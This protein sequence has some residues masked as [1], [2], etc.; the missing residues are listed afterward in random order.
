MK[1]PPAKHHR[2]AEKQPDLLCPA[3]GR[4]GSS[5]APEVSVQRSEFST[6]SQASSHVRQIHLSMVSL[7][8]INSHISKQTSYQVNGAGS[9]RIRKRLSQGCKCGCMRKLVP[10]YVASVCTH[11][12]SL[13][14]KAATHYFHT[15]YDT[16]GED[17][18]EPSSKRLRIEWYFLGHHTTVEC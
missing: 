15:A 9:V 1:G 8:M 14:D 12:H 3:V 5:S 11:L 6:A 18:S 2:L 7:L 4:A 13:S 10:T 17:S 16:C